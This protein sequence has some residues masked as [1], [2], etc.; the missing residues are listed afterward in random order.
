MAAR[1]GDLK[2]TTYVCGRVSSTAA[3]AGH[4]TVGPAALAGSASLH[5]H[6]SSWLHYPDHHMHPPYPRSSERAV[7]STSSGVSIPRLTPACSAGP[8]PELAR[9]A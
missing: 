3:T 4:E 5:H 6:P 1:S 9:S 8:S 2:Q 7:A